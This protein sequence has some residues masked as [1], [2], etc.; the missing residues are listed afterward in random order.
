MRRRAMSRM[1][2]VLE[3][4]LCRF[5][6]ILVLGAAGVSAAPSPVQTAR[7][8][9]SP[10]VVLAVT[11]DGLVVRSGGQPRWQGLWQA[12]VNPG[13]A[14]QVEPIMALAT[15]QNGHTA[16]AAGYTGTLWQ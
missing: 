16:Y 4:L 6:L 11:I 5:G 3:T 1:T 13:D 14:G 12:P 9:L 15:T 8:H 7:P 10:F 2:W